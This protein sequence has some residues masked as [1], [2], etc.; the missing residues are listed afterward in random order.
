MT[1]NRHLT[2]INRPEALPAHSDF[3]L[4]ERPLPSLAE[5]EFLIRNAY[6]SMDPA[7]RGWMVD[8]P[9]YLPPLQLG[10]PVRASTVGEVVESRA[11][12]FPIGSW[13]LGLNTLSLYSVGREGDGWSAPIDGAAPFPVTNYLSVFGTTG[14][15]A[16][17]GVR[18]LVRPRAGETVLITGA[19]GAVGS[20]AGQIARFDG[21][22]VIGVAGGAEKVERLVAEYGFDAAIDYRGKSADALVEDIAEAAPDGVDAIFENVGGTILDAGLLALNR[23]GRVALCGMISE[24]NSPADPV[25]TRQLIQLVYKSA[26]IEGF[27][28]NNYIDRI[29][30]A[31]QE[32]AGWVSS[33]RLRF[34]EQIETGLENAVTTLLK[35]FSGDHKGKLILRIAA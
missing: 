7:M 9:S 3:A 22:R 21:A 31:V 11:A 15:T 4:V 27:T 5:G 19:A 18:E 35:L 16:Y 14:L 8:A 23:A 34:D 28:F 24:Y 32:L 13:V 6:A 12:G 33:G 20:V 29:P 17:F 1:M 10:A 26:R 25:G 30:A 2:L